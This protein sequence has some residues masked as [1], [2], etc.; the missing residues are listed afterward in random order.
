M[1]S[2]TAKRHVDRDGGG[3]KGCK[4]YKRRCLFVSPCCGK[5]FPCRVC[6]DEDNTHVLDRRSVNEIICSLCNTKQSVSDKYVMLHAFIH[7]YC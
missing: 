7:F 1:S 2:E 6:H 5:T 3:N 4:H